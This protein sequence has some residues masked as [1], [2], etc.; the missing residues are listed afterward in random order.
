LPAGRQ[1]KTGKDGAPAFAKASAGQP[2]KAKAEKTSARR[3]MQMKVR[4]LYLPARAVR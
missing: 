1:A 4:G 3:A 2:G